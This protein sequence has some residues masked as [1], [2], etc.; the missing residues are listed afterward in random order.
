MLN[1]LFLYLILTI[2]CIEEYD[3]PNFNY[4]SLPYD[5][6]VQVF[7]KA[8][9][10]SKDACL[11]SKSDT[12]TILKQKYNITIDKKDVNDNLR[13]V[14]GDCNPVILIPG[15]FSVRLR[16]VVDCKGLYNNERD[17]YKKVK[18]FCSDYICPKGPEEIPHEY[19][20]FL[21]VDGAFGFGKSDDYKN[22]YNACFSF[23]MTIFNNDEC[24]LKKGICTKSD[25][26]KITFEGGTNSTYKDSQCGVHAIKDV[27]LSNGFLQYISDTSKVYGEITRNLLDHTGYKYGF[28]YGGIPNDFRKF[29]IIAKKEESTCILRKTI[30]KYK[31]IDDTAAIFP[32]CRGGVLI[33]PAAPVCRHGKYK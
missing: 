30:V 13:F 3:Y 14:V 29:G 31:S 22:I 26:I 8:V 15:I 11:P 25:Y 23:F 6:K 12:I 21:E 32:D 4:D 18:F 10:A 19:Y 9:G 2:K 24:P 17:V 7:L 1:M 16:A 5:Q 20:L 33:Y 28:S 27:F